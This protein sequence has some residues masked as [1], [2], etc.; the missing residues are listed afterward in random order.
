M[1]SIHEHIGTMAHDEKEINYSTINI[2]DGKIMM[3][4]S[5]ILFRE[6]GVLQLGDN[7]GY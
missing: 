5:F 3:I 7:Y 1:R 6:M 2:F 4:Q